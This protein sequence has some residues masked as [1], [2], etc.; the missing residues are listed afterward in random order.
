MPLPGQT[1]AAQT[2]VRSS[3][4]MMSAIPEKIQVLI[5]SFSTS[6]ETI[7]DK[8]AIELEHIPTPTMIYHY[9]DGAGLRGILESGKFRFTD[10]FN[11]NDPAELRHGLHFAFEF[12]QV[13]ADKG[14]PGMRQFT[15]NVSAMLRTEIEQIAHFF[16]CCFS[17]SADDL[18]QWRAYADNGR[19]FALGF[20]GTMLERAYCK[21]DAHPIPG[22]MT[23]PI[24]YNDDQLR[25]IHSKIIELVRPVVLNILGRDATDDAINMYIGKIMTNLSVPIIRS[26]LFF[27]HKAYKNENEYR[28]LEMHQAGLVPDL[29]FR[30]RPYSLVRYREIDWRTEAASALKSIIIGPA[31]D[32]KIAFQFVSDCLRAFH[33]TKAIVNITQSDI[34]YRAP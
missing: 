5:D 16:I 27:K 19:G 30:G 26:A 12:L 20:D 29:K 7:V 25:E 32:K 13:E 22:R 4:N 8:F 23:F 17:I 31:A 3:E 33:T 11:L 2:F 15:R 34:P 14:P 28:F 24:T 18:G 9:T 6:V 10:I 1:V 21:A